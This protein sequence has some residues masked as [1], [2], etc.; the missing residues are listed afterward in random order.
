MALWN[1]LNHDQIGVTVINCIL[2]TQMITYYKCFCSVK[3]GEIKYRVFVL[4]TKITFFTIKANGLYSL[5]LSYHKI[6]VEVKKIPFWD[7]IEC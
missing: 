3:L 4:L 6:N 2:S 5:Y 1:I 7:V